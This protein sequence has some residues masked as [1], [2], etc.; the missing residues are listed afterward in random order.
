VKIFSI[1]SLICAARALDAQT[2]ANV[3]VRPLPA[4]TAVSTEALGSLAAVRQ[5]PD[6]KVLVNDQAGRRVLLMDSALKVLDVVA[7]STSR[8]A[9]AYGPRPGGLIAYRGDSTLFVD[10]ASLSMLVIDP[11]GKVTR[12]IAAPR[13]N[14]VQFLVGGPFGNPGFDAQG[15][16]VYR[17]FF[18]PA[19]APPV[20]GRAPV[21][22]VFP[23]T[24]AL[25][26]FDL[27]AR[28]L[29]TAAFIKIPKLTMNVSQDE[30]GGMRLTSLNNPLP[31]VDDWAVM[32]DGTLAIVRGRD[33]RVEFLNADGTR[34]A[35]EKIPFEWQRLT[36]EDKVALIDSAK[37]MAARQRAAGG[38]PGT[39]PTRTDAAPG[40]VAG[41]LTQ[42][43]TMRVDGG[44]AG[45]PAATSVPGGLPPVAFVAPSE[46]PDYKPAFGVGSVRA[47]A[48]GFVWVRTIPT[49]PTT[50]GA[51]YEVI[52]RAGKLVDRV[53][54]PAG[55]TIAGFG[56]G[57]VVYLGVRDA[58]GVHLQRARIPRG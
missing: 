9:S 25:V 24:A 43:V 44:G 46:L 37:A 28:K 27:A 45:G 20:A 5:L 11:T 4:P 41:A 54:V 12:V 33:Y 22:P 48:D 39:T 15:R 23:D 1:M 17:S 31:V 2:A 58:A 42:I 35:G 32:S 19:F 47:D 8:T 50:G 14:D 18:R 29:D 53:Q 57:G 40:G 21:M 7:D 52:D 34:T 51:V 30:R 26:R 10:P 55:T 38:A 36:D 16:L 49:K 6:G 13:A 56:K 3:P